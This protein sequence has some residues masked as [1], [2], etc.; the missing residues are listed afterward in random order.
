MS[1]H[2]LFL[3]T[4]LGCSGTT[5]QMADDNEKAL[6]VAAR[7]DSETVRRLLK[8][9]VKVDVR[10]EHGR[11]PLL[12]AVHHNQVEAARL[13]IEAG[14]DVNAQDRMQD[15]PLLF[16]GAEGRLEILRLILKAKPNFKVYNRYGGTALI[17]AC[18]RGHVEV[19]KELIK[20]DMDINHINRL[21]WTALL[22]AIILSEGGP[23]HQEIVRLLVK[24]RANVNLADKEGVS[25]LHHARQRGYTDIVK[26]LEAAGA[27]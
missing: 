23:K 1:S 6:L 3:I 26:I 12:L 20:T 5:K 18:E 22:E 14:A 4:L 24:A 9:G 25:P 13:V 21:G 15:S 17:P 19:V 16:A 2:I 7:N 8:Q 27:K 10:D 11:T